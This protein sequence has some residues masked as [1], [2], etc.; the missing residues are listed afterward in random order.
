MFIFI[1]GIATA[2]NFIVILWKLSHNRV[3]DGVI[4]FGTFVAIGY[5]FAGTMGG[6]AIG[7]VASAFISVYLLVSP[8][9]FTV[10]KRGANATT[11]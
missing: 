1:A 3:L 10:P 6:M 8:P 5:L 2:F 11:T 9:Q 7:M 4:D